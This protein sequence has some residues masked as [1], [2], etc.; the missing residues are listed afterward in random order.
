MCR[1]RLHRYQ[2]R[3]FILT[4]IS[5]TVYTMIRLPYSITKSTLHPDV[6][7][8]DQPG[9]QPFN[10]DN[11]GFY[12]G[13][14][15]SCFLLAYSIGLFFSGAIGNEHHQSIDLYSTD[16]ACICTIGDH[17]NLKYFIGIGMIGSSIFVA[18][19]GAARVWNIH[20]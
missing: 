9:W 10:Q 17:V 14:L 5:Y 19:F 2:T 20:C 8:I 15:D 12:L 3:V 11:G 1:T 6:I 16:M 18:L 13:A 4:F 7:T